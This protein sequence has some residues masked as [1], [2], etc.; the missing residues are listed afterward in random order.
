MKKLLVAAAVGMLFMQ[1]ETKK[2]FTIT[3]NVTGYKDGT[4]VALQSVDEA[5]VLEQTTIE[6]NAFEFEGYAENAPENYMVVINDAERPDFYSLLIGNEDVVIFGDKKDFPYKVKIKGSKFADDA[7]KLN[8]M[9]ADLGARRQQIEEEYFSLPENQQVTDSISDFYWGDNGK[10]TVIDTKVDSIKSA[11]VRANPNSE[12]A[13]DQ[14]R[15]LLHTFTKDELKAL[16]ASLPPELKKDRRARAINDYAT[17]ND[18]VVG[19]KVPNFSALD[20]EDKSHDM[21]SL[22]KKKKYTLLDFTT[23]HCGYCTLSIP[24]IRKAEQKYRSKLQVVS[25][26]IDSNKDSWEKVNEEENLP[27]LRLITKEGRYSKPYMQ[28]KIYGTP[29]FFLVDSNGTLLHSWSGYKENIE[30]EFAHLLR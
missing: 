15:Y 2:G 28:Y 29:A 19:K 24:G 23:P 14:L 11:Y 21:Y 3:G 25:V 5:K 20:E 16:Y 26:C 30:K 1:C 8:L 10:A 22:F 17:A 4:V 7:N 27:W 18:I 6:D 9:I 12:F 13:L